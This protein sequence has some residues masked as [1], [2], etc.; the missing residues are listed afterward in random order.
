MA[1]LALTGL[2]R[3]TDINAAKREVPAEGPSLGVAP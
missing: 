1:K 3:A 2:L